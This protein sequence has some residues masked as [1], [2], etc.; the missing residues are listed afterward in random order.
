MN[1]FNIIE[2]HNRLAAAV[3]LFSVLPC[4]RL[5][6][7]QMEHRQIEKCSKQYVR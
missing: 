2:S 6:Y 3:A 7:L 4:R 5:V 1:Q